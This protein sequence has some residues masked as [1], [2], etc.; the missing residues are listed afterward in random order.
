MRISLGAPAALPD[1][2]AFANRFHPQRMLFGGGDGV[3]WSEFLTQPVRHWL[4]E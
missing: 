1:L 2:V 4:S 3:D